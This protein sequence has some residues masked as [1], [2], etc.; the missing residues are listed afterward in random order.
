MADRCCTAVRYNGS[1]T[2][3]AGTPDDS[4]GVPGRT[5]RRRWDARVAGLR[6]RHGWIDH[7][8]RAAAHYRG[9]RI[10]YHALVVVSRGLFL[11]I[12]GV[13]VFLY[14]LSF[15]TDLLPGTNELVI[16]TATLPDARDLGSVVDEALVQFQSAV[17]GIVGLVTLLVSATLTARALRN[18]T[19]RSRRRRR[20][21]VRA[22]APS[23]LLIGLGPALMILISGCWR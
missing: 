12:A 14:V 19:R 9:D 20:P 23:N 16:P 4:S 3:P 5:L 8:A 22:L 15:I 6:A 7:L 13:M 21:Q 2:A 11:T 1:P 17:L 18:G 10:E